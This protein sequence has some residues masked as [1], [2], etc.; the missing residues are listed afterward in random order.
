MLILV[1]LGDSDSWELIKDISSLCAVD[2]FDSF[3]ILLND[4]TDLKHIIVATHFYLKETVNKRGP[5]VLEK[6]KL[7]IYP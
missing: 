4:G 5:K 6:C 1:S 3:L 2:F 7:Q